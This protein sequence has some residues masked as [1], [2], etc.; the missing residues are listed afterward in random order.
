M[1]PIVRRG[2]P[3]VWAAY[4][5]FGLAVPGDGSGRCRRPP[6]KVSAFP[7]RTLVRRKVCAWLGLRTRSGPAFRLGCCR[8]GRSRP[9]APASAQGFTYNRSRPGET[10][11]AVK[12]ADVVQAVEVDYDYNNQRVSAVATCRC[13]ITHQRRGRQV[14]Y[15]QRPSGFMRR[16]VRHDRCGRSSHLRQLMDLSDDYRDGFVIRC[17][18]IPRCDANGATRMDVPAQLHRFRER[19]LYCLRACGTT[20]RNRRCGRSRGAHYSRPDRQDAV[21]SRTRS[22][23]SSAFRWPICRIFPRQIRPEAQDRVPDAGVLFDYGMVRR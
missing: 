5:F 10:A 1:H 20:R 2:C 16:N 18:S 4:R 3:F 21:L 7:R 9:K 14:I 19:R 15:D 17:A 12:R 11:A 13:S 8:T 22:W 6:G 23:S